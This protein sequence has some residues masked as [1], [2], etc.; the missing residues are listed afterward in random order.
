[1]LRWRCA[2][3]DLEGVVVVAVAAVAVVAVEARAVLIRAA[4]RE[5]RIAGHFALRGANFGG[6]A[7]TVNEVFFIVLARVHRGGVPRIFVARFF[8][9]YAKGA[10][11]A[12][13]LTATLGTE[14]CTGIAH[15]LPSDGDVSARPSRRE[16]ATFFVELEP[17]S[18]LLGVDA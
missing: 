9:G 10:P 14:A 17:A 7:R 11:S 13:A 12:H 2:S 8:R 4:M 6:A 18:L 3:S 5:A 16:K 15:R 1:M